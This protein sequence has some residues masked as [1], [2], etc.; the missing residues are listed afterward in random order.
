MEKLLPPFNIKT[1]TTA[2]IQPL[3]VF[4]YDQRRDYRFVL[5]QG[6]TLGNA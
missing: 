5:A 1:K 2:P 4:D 6:K 3:A